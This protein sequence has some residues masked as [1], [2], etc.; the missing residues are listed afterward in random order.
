[1]KDWIRSTF[2]QQLTDLQTIIRIPSVS[3]GD[4]PEPG[5]PFGRTVHR[6]L[7]ETL[8]IARRLGFERVW[9]TDGYCGVVEY[10][11]GEETLA[12]LAHLDVVPEGE[13]W[14][15]DPYGGIVLDG[16][17]FGRGTLDDKGAAVSAL[18]ALAAVKES[19]RKMR[20]RVRIVL[21]CDEERGS[22]G[23][24]HYL[25]VEGEPTMAFTPDA[26]YPVVNS[27]MGILQT[28]YHKPFDSAVRIS[29]GTASNV[30]PG[31]AAATLPVP[32]KPVSV[33]EGFS[34]SFEGNTVTV[35]G[36]GGHASMPELA[37]NA[38]QALLCV[39]QQQALGEE[40]AKLFGALSALWGMDRHGE[41]L[42]I[43]VTDAS[44]R[45]T[46]SPD[47]MTVDE[48]GI[49]FVTDC[50][51]PFSVTA[52]QLL[53]V[54]DGAYGALGFVR[55]DTREAAGH[56]IPEDSE[57]VSTLMQVYN[58][59]NGGSAKPLS[60][61]GGTYARE[62]K[63]AVAFGIVR[64]GEESLCHMPDESISLADME[65]NTLVMANAI[66]RLATEEVCH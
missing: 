51:H 12:I 49:T 8:D 66:V 20:R 64:E 50:R 14:S 25:K 52:Q 5:K 9:D 37:K 27:E 58:E 31:T 53:A 34:A 4:A 41:S 15:V 6:C 54:W 56:F 38:L 40:E 3:R 26:E 59:I 33:P 47:C 2:S 55:T 30:I 61:G 46:F 22:L 16:R 10:G 11:E 44:G 63:N 32:V 19:G 65:F 13:G 45:L 17:I 29:V 36:R 18:Y 21:G 7:T 39:L 1:M 60:M 24:E 28:T 43:D 57:L 62:M 48:T 42:G 23:V 35:T